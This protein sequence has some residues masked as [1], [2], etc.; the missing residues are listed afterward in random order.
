VEE[1]LLGQL[2]QLCQ[3]RGSRHAAH[4][5]AQLHKQ[6]DPLGRRGG[7]FGGGCRVA[8][9]GARGQKRSCR[10]RAG[11]CISSSTTPARVAPGAAQ[12]WG[13][14]GCDASTGWGGAERPHRWRRRTRAWAGRGGGRCA[15]PP[16]HA[17]WSAAAC[18]AA[19]PGARS[20]RADH[21]AHQ[22]RAMWVRGVAG[23]PPEA[24]RGWLVVCRGPPGP[25][26]GV[27]TL[28]CGEADRGASAWCHPA[29]R[30]PPP[31]CAP[32]P[33]CTAPCGPR[34]VPAAR[35][36][37]PASE[38][39]RIAVSA[40]QR[41][42]PPLP[43]PSNSPADPTPPRSTRR[44]LLRSIRFLHQC[45]RATLRDWILGFSWEHPH[46]QQDDY[47]GKS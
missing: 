27:E 5:P 26:P 18:A 45:T 44:Q 20:R 12:L 40:E 29:R 17:R 9:A 39:V 22:R 46:P 30:E 25:G 34:D 32:C 41:V 38:L 47:H 28:G 10:C 21:R 15:P 4:E 37:C 36:T 13:H 19:S 3:A 2:A 33:V 42:V 1:D 24:G 31:A 35:R 8:Q 23:L 11:V 16:E 43:A 7:T 6:L 14:G